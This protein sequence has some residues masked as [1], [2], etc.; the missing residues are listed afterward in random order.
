MR[1]EKDDINYHNKNIV[2][3]CTS[4]SQAGIQ[5]TWFGTSARR[6]CTEVRGRYAGKSEGG[7]QTENESIVSWFWSLKTITWGLKDNRVPKWQQS[8]D[9]IVQQ[10]LNRLFMCGLFSTRWV[11]WLPYLCDRMHMSEW[12]TTRGRLR[13][14]TVHGYVYGLIRKVCR[15]STQFRVTGLH[16][17][18][19]VYMYVWHCGAGDRVQL[20]LLLLLVSV[21][22]TPHNSQAD[23]H[24]VLN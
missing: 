6:L 3:H 10:V 8:Y 14:Y 15:D 17:R 2:Y 4:Q 13:T 18:E 1:E 9:Y 12:N 19:W 23:C 7:F 21:R 20:V 5:V 22:S 16:R 11:F 24:G